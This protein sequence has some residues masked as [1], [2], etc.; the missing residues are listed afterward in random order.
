M[1]YFER[2]SISSA[3]LRWNHYLNELFGFRF[4]G[5]DTETI[6][7]SLNKHLDELQCSINKYKEHLTNIILELFYLSNFKL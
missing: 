4:N 3:I 1:C 6:V 7:S 2:A 5:S